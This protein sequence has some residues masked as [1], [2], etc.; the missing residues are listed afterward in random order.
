MEDKKIIDFSLDDL[1][2]PE[3]SRVAK[4]TDGMVCLIYG[5][6]GLGKTPVAAHMEK[7]Y[8]LAFGKSGLSGL[9]RVPFKSINSWADFK[10]FNKTLTDKANFKVLHERFQTIIFDEMEVLW[11]YCEK[12]VANCEGVNKIKEGNGGYGLW[13][14]LKDEWE[15][16]LLKVIGSG[17]CIMFILHTAPDETGRQFP[18]GDVKRMLPILINHSEIVGYVRGNGVDQDTG[19]PIHSSLVLAGSDECFART[20]ND[21]FDPIIEDFTA[22]NLVK[23]YYTAIERQEKAEGIEAV[24]KEER[25]ELF[26]TSK[27]DFDDLMDAVM[28]AGEAVVEKYGSK[29]KITEV[30]ENVLGKGALVST[31]TPK[32][33]EAVE[34]ILNDLESLL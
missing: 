17:F 28:K 3:E 15:S 13:G 4:T 12:Y 1:L 16:E 6:G 27:R 24:T 5:Y 31:C 14:D 34:I 22:E 30:V 8:Y 9:N 19:R 33:Q 32:Q 29:D 23:A 20:R 11:K 18:V 7:P 10:K 25:D 26:E 2:N 21:Y